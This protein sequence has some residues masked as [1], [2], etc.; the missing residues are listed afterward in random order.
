MGRPRSDDRLVF[1]GIWILCS[2]TAWRDLPE[3][4][5][6]WSMVYQRFRDWRDDGTFDQ[7]LER[8]H[9]LLNQEGLIDLDTWMVDSTA[10][11]A[12]RASSGARRKGAGRTARP[13]IGTQPRWPDHQDSSDLRCQWD[14]PSLHAFAR[15]GQ[16]YCTCLAALGSSAYPR[17]VGTTS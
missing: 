3:R 9:V 17:K 10:V 12:T 11:R 6:P 2:G 14:S 1:N 15:T 4:F 7:M 13:R 8:L 5:G 16:R